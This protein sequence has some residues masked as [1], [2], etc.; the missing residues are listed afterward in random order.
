MTAY[1]GEADYHHG[2]PSVTGL[3]V[4]NLGTPDAP[5][6][7]A[8]RRYLAEF[9][10]DP[11]IVEIPR[12][13][14]WLILHGVIL[15]FRPKRSA[16]AY[17]SIWT[18][19]GSPLL[20]ISRRQAA[21]LQ[22]ALEQQ[23]SGPVKVVLGM[24]YGNPS[25]ADALHELR[26]AHARR[27][28]VLPLYPQY[29]AATTAST[30]DAVADELKT[31]RWVPELR[32]VQHYQ[33]DPLY[34]AALAASIRESW[35]AHGQAERL[36]FSFHG[37]PKRSF[38]AG[39]PYFCECQ[40]TARLVAEQLQL[41]AERWQVTFQSRLGKAEWLKP[42]TDKTLEAWGKE[43]V[44]SVDVVCPGFSADCLETLE[45]IA[46]LNRGI[47]L[48][49]GGEKYRYIPALNDRPDH[50]QALAA[51]VMRHTQGWVETNPAWNAAQQAIEAEASR[52]RALAM[53]AQR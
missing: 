53:G 35:A 2:T 22:A 31:W 15:P 26:K 45:E 27:I 47:F 37:I 44:K 25:I 5:T 12:P 30:F 21:A 43:G 20:A 46:M 9:L 6:T 36:L 4:T 52:R 38:L 13:V 23:F 48:E 34:I 49:A 51:L 18:D 7:P 17:Q 24:R 14:W 28:L 40:K 19:E 3:L 33:D 16:H 32:M 29:A 1:Q 11:R 10:W 39:D 8:L 41:P 50:I 42:Y